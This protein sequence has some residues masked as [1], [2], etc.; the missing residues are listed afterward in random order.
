MRRAWI[1]LALAAGCKSAQEIKLERDLAQAEAFETQGEP[2]RAL[3][4]YQSWRGR[5]EDPEQEAELRQRAKRA[6]DAAF[7]QGQR[8]ESQRQYRAAIL[9]YM[10]LSEH[11]GDLLGGTIGAALAGARQAAYDQAV[12]EARQYE[13][14]GRWREA[15]QQ[16]ESVEGIASDI[17]RAAELSN[18]LHAA[19]LKF[20]DAELARADGLESG[21]D[22]PA[23]VALYG[24]LKA[25]GGKIGRQAEPDTRAARARTKWMEE[26]TERAAAHTRAGAW[27]KAIEAWEWGRPAARELGREAEVIRGVKNA[28]ISS[29]VERAARLESKEEWAAAIQVYEQAEAMAQEVGRIDEIS[30]KLSAARDRRYAQAIDAAARHEG[31]GQW[32]RAVEEY[33]SVERIASKTGRTDELRGRL[34]RA[35]VEEAFAEARAL[36][37]AGRWREAIDRYESA[38]GLGRDAE[39]AERLGRARSEHFE[40]QL[41]RAESM[42]RRQEFQAA[43]EALMEARDSAKHA[44]AEERFSDALIRL[45]K[46]RFEQALDQARSHRHREDFEQAHK[47]Y[48][49]LRTLA[50]ELGREGDLEAQI[51][52]CREDQFNHLLDQAR[53]LEQQDRWR[54]ALT[55]YETLR[56]MAAEVGQEAALRKSIERAQNGWLDALLAQGR[57]HERNERWEE[58]VRTYEEALAVAR[59]IG[60]EREAERRLAAAREELHF[61]GFHHEFSELDSLEMPGHVV[62]VVFDPAGSWYAAADATGQIWIFEA[63]RKC[64]CKM[65]I[66]AGGCPRALSFSPCGRFL[67]A[68]V[69]RTVLI[70]EARTGR[71]LRS[72]PFHQDCHAVAFS[73]DSEA[74]LVGLENGS[75]ELWT[76]RHARCVRAFRGHRHCVNGIYWRPGNAAFLSVCDGGE[77]RVWTFADGGCA[78]NWVGHRRG[79]RQVYIGSSGRYFAT[80]G[81]DDFVYVWSFDTWEIVARI[82]HRGASSCSFAGG[83]RIVVI[84]DGAGAVTMWDVRSGRRVHSHACHT[85]GASWVSYHPGGRTFVTCGQ[86]RRVRIWGHRE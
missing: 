86:D 37:S 84:A 55:S 10:K 68:S 74:I 78:R 40:A 34:N 32:R 80:V 70:W 15:V 51:R 31:E 65:R 72:L 52:R 22:W 69:G 7:A 41:K 57:S 21:G 82:E 23:A 64:A 77:I 85:G 43:I 79:I 4:I 83:D 73:P 47:T 36:E 46:A 17:G 1:L 20:F 11:A 54:E 45:K 26:A 29:A 3:Q 6:A 8:M 48:E 62:S 53:R 27:D 76:F 19:R 28:R 56:P 58:A 61:R 39:V 14:A 24:S 16:Y 30:P 42:E 18:A 49:S 71:L 12:G 33:R 60:R 50:R 75:I 44:G 25:L 67:A 66:A 63:G 35:R 13:S 38:R 2:I 81:G 59:E 5:T 9:H